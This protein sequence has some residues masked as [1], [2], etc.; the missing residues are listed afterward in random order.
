MRA[1]VWCVSLAAFGLCV[2]VYV[3]LWGEE[4]RHTLNVACLAAECILHYRLW[5]AGSISSITNPGAWQELPS[6]AGRELGLTPSDTLD[7]VG[8][9][10]GLVGCLGFKPGW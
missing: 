5:F 8:V 1:D 9:A 10:V 4:P 2:T 6:L 3:S 7:W